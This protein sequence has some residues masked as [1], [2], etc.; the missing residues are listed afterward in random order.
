MESGE[1]KNLIAIKIMRKI[2]IKNPRS[3]S[4]HLNPDLIPNPNH[5]LTLFL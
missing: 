5:R 1:T 4:L 2:T 3:S